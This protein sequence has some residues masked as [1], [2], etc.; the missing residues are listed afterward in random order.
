MYCPK[1]G[2]E[3]AETNKFCRARRENASFWDYVSL[4]RL[5]ASG[6]RENKS[7][8]QPAS[9]PDSKAELP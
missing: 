3:N 5:S 6:S 9:P 4:Q 1:C 8:S 7:S 2:T